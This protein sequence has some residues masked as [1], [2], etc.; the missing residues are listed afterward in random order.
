[1]LQQGPCHLYDADSILNH[2]TNKCP[3][4]AFSN[5]FYETI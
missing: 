5:I 1:V 3:N 2:V 4:S